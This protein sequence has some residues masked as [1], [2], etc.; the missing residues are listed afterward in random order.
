[1][2]LRIFLFLFIVVKTSENEL[3]DTEMKNLMLREKE[4]EIENKKRII[5]NNPLYGLTYVIEKE[6]SKFY[7]KEIEIYFSLIDLGLKNEVK[8]TPKDS[9]NSTLQNFKNEYLINYDYLLGPTNKIYHLSN[10][11]KNPLHTYLDSKNNIT[12][13]SELNSTSE[14]LLEIFEYKNELEY[15]PTIKI[16]LLRNTYTQQTNH[17]LPLFFYKQEWKDFYD[18]SFIINV[19]DSS[20]LRFHEIDLFKFKCF[21][22]YESVRNFILN[23]NPNKTIPNQNI[24]LKLKRKTKINKLIEKKLLARNDTHINLKNYLIDIDLSI[25]NTFLERI[26]QELSIMENFNEFL[27]DEDFNNNYLICSTTIDSMIEFL[28]SKNLNGKIEK[29]NFY[30]YLINFFVI[31]SAIYLI[32]R[33]L[34]D[35]RNSY[36][37]KII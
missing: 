23:L 11:S 36:R 7:N 18:M 35:V 6:I 27:S 4:I 3:H 37:K 22:N 10:L 5:D 13:Q 8:F 25:I 15:L 33:T 34:L 14:V 17:S 28:N 1:M 24:N 19:N 32:L 26:G 9:T 12:N 29:Q 31:L 2:Y 20:C 30:Y 21:D 16:F